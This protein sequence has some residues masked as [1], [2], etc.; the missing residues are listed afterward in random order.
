MEQSP[1]WEAEVPKKSKKKKKTP[2][3][4]PEGP[5][6]QPHESNPRFYIPFL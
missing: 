2:H 4:Q 6:P 5:Y 3:M 1:Y